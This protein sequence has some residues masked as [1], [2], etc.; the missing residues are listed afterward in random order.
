MRWS[1]W[2]TTTGSTRRRS[3]I[4]APSSGSA[5]TKSRSEQ[6]RGAAR[7]NRRQSTCRC[8]RC[9]PKALPGDVAA[10]DVHARRAPARSSTRLVSAMPPMCCIQQGLDNGFRIERAVRTV[11]RNRI[12]ACGDELQSRRSRQGH[13]DVPP[14]EGAA[15][16]R[17]DRSASRRAS[18]RS[19]R[20]LRR[21]RRRW[22][23]IRTA[24]RRQVARLGDD[25]DE[26]GWRWW[27]RW[28]L[29][30]RRAPRRSRATLRDASERRPPRV[31]LHR[32][33]D[34]RREH[35]GRRRR[36]RR[37]CTSRRSSGGQRQR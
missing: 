17:R 36:A 31:Q 2:S 4:S 28:R 19:S 3:R 8:R 30:S 15:L 26:L 29:R 33:R 13:A 6:F 5:A 25:E 34:D 7:S 12:E 35:S 11:C 10:A 20:G 37:R 18:S 32:P 27:Q 9:S 24:R 23:R 1:R 21:P 16:R 22:P 14:D